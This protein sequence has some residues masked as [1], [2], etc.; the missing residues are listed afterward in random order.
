MR[1]RYDLATFERAVAMARAVRPDLALTGDVMV[2]FPGETGEDFRLTLDAIERAGFMGLHVFRFSPR[3][4]TAAARYADQVPAPE[5]RE[6]SRRA[7][8]L[9][10]RLRA[11][12]E[13]RFEGRP[14]QGRHRELSPGDG[15]VGRPP[16][17]PGRGGRLARRGS[18]G[19]SATS[20]FQEWLEG[21]GLDVP[22]RTYPDGTRTAEDAARAIGCEV[23][24]IVKSLVFTAGGR[25]VIALVSGSNRLDTRRLAELAGAPVAR[26]DADLARSATGYS[27]GGVPPFGH[28]TALPVYMDRDLTRHDLVWAAAG[29]PD[30][31]FPISPSR[32]AEL[33]G[34]TVE[35]LA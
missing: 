30:A 6:R 17:G 2:G 5:A 14:D 31:V 33:S 11:A 29:R 34:A 21:R 10:H 27:I 23:A 7:I 9:G 35:R 22:I 15:A 24:Q 4:R 3:P 32:L 28:A 19:V 13:S 1:R 20:R 8:E 16:A 18:G 12:Y 26:A 25:P